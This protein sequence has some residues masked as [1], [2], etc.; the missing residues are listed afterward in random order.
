MKAVIIGGGAVSEMFHIPA[1]LEVLGKESVFLAE[2]NEE[3]REKMKQKFG[4]LHTG[5]DYR[6]FLNA[7]D[8]AIV[9]TP[10]HLHLEIMRNCMEAKV[11][12]LCEKPVAL[13]SAECRELLKIQQVH[14]VQVALCHTYRF[15]P[16]RQEVRGKL[17]TGLSG[18]SLSVEEGEPASW[19]TVSGYNFRKEL[20][21]G[22]VLLDAGIH[23]LD[24][25]L[26]CLGKPL[27]IEYEDD[28]LGGLESNLRLQLTFENE[29]KA[30]FRL[31]RTCNLSNKIQ[32]QKPSE[33]ME[34]DIFEMQDYKSGNEI[35]QAKASE[36]CEWSTIAAIQLRDFMRAVETNSNPMCTLEEGAAVIELIE[37]CYQM[38]KERT[39]PNVA[40][41][42]G[43]TF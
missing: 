7:A 1:S 34:L 9:A 4:L 38:K 40:P 13:N 33:N 32:I 8:I 15:F 36:N 12:I 27:A 17:Q 29:V 6:E 16:N 19:E 41:L 30:F 20:V 42:P 22:G 2:P 11:H 24:F 5:K 14:D 26:W 3:Q 28:S 21:P 31:S 39:L 10:P 35:I 25:I 23:S 43:Q 18:V 37:R